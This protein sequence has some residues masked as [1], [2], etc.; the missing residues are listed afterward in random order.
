LGRVCGGEFHA[1]RSCRAAPAADTASQEYPQ[2]GGAPGISGGLDRAGARIV[3]AELVRGWLSAAIAARI[4]C[5]RHLCA[6]A[7][8]VQRGRIDG[9]R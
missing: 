6:L 1:R 3:G 2:I 8:P 5:L 7:A 9:P 4:G